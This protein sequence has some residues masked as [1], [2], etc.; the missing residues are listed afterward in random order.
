M[1]GTALAYTPPVTTKPLTLLLL[2]CL[3]AS[4]G[5]DRKAPTPPQPGGVSLSP[6]AWIV[7]Y[8]SGVRLSALQGLA[9]WFFAFPT[10]PG[11]VNY[12]TT[13]YT[14]PLS[15]TLTFTAQV[16]VTSGAPVVLPAPE[17]SNVCGT[18]TSVRA[19]V[20]QVY[21]PRG[22]G[23]GIE[24]APAT[25][26]WWSNPIAMQLT[27][28]T[29]TVSTPITPDQWSD[30]EGQF[31]T[32]QPAGWAEAFAHPAAVGLTFGGGC[33]FGHG[34]VVQEGSARFVLTGFVIQ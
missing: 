28:G 20:E 25:Y 29:A 13:A 24:F 10:E 33:F 21:K 16:V 14:A 3:G 34:V 26:R 7:R 17:A 30:T 32:D 4:L 5:A 6:S 8:S 31:G 22:P 1:G 19:Y 2:A 12:I 18:L 15:G 27:E 9:G 11:H 23:H